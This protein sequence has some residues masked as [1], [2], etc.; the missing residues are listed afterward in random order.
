MWSKRECCQRISLR[1]IILR[2][3]SAYAPMPEIIIIA[4]KVRQHANWSN[5]TDFTP[6][7][8]R[9]T[10][11]EQV[12]FD[13]SHFSFKSFTYSSIIQKVRTGVEHCAMIIAKWTE[14]SSVRDDFYLT[15][16]SFGSFLFLFF[17]QKRMQIH[18]Y[19]N[20]KATVSRMQTNN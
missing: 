5:W 8:A 4:W 17:G 15:T 3:G 1:T 6:I 20:H 19:T 14:I 16:F 13:R 9:E 2:D 18:R 10:F 7:P 12:H 11:M